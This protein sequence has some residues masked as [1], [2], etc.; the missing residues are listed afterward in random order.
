AMG[1]GVSGP[2]PNPNNRRLVLVKYDTDGSYLWHHFPQDENVTSTELEGFFWG[3]SQSNSLIAEP[4]GTLYWHCLFFPGNHL[5]GQLVVPP[6]TSQYNA[7]LR[8]DKDGNYQ[9]HFQLPLMGGAT[10]NFT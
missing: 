7:V 2:N 8:Y 3:I 4:N 6:S 9:G 1:L 5:N 10:N